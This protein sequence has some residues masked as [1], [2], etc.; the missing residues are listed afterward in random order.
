MNKTIKR[1]TN[2]KGEKF[3]RFQ[4]YLG[5]NEV[6]GTSVYV[7]RR[8]FTKYRDA[9]NEY[10]DI[11]EQIKKGTFKVAT[12]KRYKVSDL[13]SRW[14]K[15]YKTTVKE[16]TFATTK[17][18]IDNHILPQLGNIYLDKLA[19]DRCEKA[20]NVWCEEAP[21][22]FKRYIRYTN[23]FLDYGVNIELIASNP[24]RKVI[25]P[26]IAS[27]VDKFTDFYTKKELDKFLTVCK[28]SQPLKVYVFFR[29]LAY[30]G[31]RKGEALALTWNDI[32]LINN[33]I[34]VNKALTT[35][36]N[37]RLIVGTP[38]TQNSVRTLDMDI[39]T[40]NILKEWHQEQ[41]K[42]L[43][44]IG[45]NGLNKNQLIFSNELNE[46][47]FPSKPTEWNN[48]T[49][50]A[51]GLRHIKTHGFRHTHAS[52]LFESGASME[53]VKER[54]GHSKIETTM[55]IYTHVSRGRKKQTATQFAEYMK[56]NG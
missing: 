39:E 27:K 8:G 14:E 51:G 3:Y 7:K 46:L 52:L 1:Y 32:D 34:S 35:G 33:T 16:S 31:M 48:R 23:N 13:I 47:I 55:N 28:A 4:I 25:R 5:K 11:Q 19:V 37:N 12:E 29:L 10:K 38:K 30:S 22:T 53:D 24:M 45:I 21:R 41:I 44:K 15:Y 26:K 6:T 50:L 20:V 42:E 40:M 54:L 49:C 18:I 17:R 9:L 36:F 43:F 56:S 2:K